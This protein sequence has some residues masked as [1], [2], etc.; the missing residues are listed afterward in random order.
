[1]S[2]VKFQGEADGTNK[3]PFCQ[4]EKG[5]ISNKGSESLVYA[6][7]YFKVYFEA[8][9][10]NKLKKC[11]KIICSHSTFFV[12]GWQKNGLNWMVSLLFLYTLIT[13]VQTV[14]ILAMIFDVKRKEISFYLQNEKM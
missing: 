7:K 3:P 2:W 1:M 13:A 9:Y 8:S 5:T 6:R 14:E 10:N 4:R 12:P 11:M